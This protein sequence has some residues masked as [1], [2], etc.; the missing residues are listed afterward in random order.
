[1]TDL[2]GA[3]V[4]VL[5]IAT[6]T[7]QDGGLPSVPSVAG[8]FRDLRT[9]LIERCGV[10]PEHVTAVLDPADAQSMA[11]AVARATKRADT[12]LLVYFIG[13]GLLTPGGDL[14]LAAGNTAELTPGMAE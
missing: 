5:L 13:H 14:Y 9:A 3:G 10:R 1:M 12:V 4:Q 6:A 11:L 2:D 8:S 7:H